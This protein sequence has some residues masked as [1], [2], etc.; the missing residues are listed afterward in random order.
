MK[1]WPLLVLCEDYRM[2]YKTHILY[3]IEVKVPTVAHTCKVV[4][5]RKKTKREDSF[6]LNSNSKFQQKI[7]FQTPG[8]STFPTIIILQRESSSHS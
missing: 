4:K 3:K 7:T 5:Q 8:G 2:I 6:D 1:S